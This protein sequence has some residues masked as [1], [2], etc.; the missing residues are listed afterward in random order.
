[1]EKIVWNDA[2]SVGVEAIDAEH[3]Q[4][5]IL[6]NLLADHLHLPSNAPAVEEIMTALS[7]FAA[8]HFAREEK[9]LDVGGSAEA[10]L[11]ATSHRRFVDTMHQIAHGAAS[12]RIHLGR[13]HG[14]LVP[15]WSSHILD[16]D[17]VL[18][19]EQVAARH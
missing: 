15:W 3:Q 5:A 16:Q 14:F 1:M 10:R 19:P 11:H 9:H 6:I 18:K 13:F 8:Y 4:L 12:G 7:S 2:F 17:M